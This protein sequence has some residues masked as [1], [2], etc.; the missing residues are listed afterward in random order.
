MPNIVSPTTKGSTVRGR[1]A[2]VFFARH[3]VSGILWRSI[4]IRA[5]IISDYSGKEKV[6]LSL[7]SFGV[8]E[9]LVNRTS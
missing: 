3:G 7:T 4:A 5:T 6:R 8:N 9:G 2:Q 1:T